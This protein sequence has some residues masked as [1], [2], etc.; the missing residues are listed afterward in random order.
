M[1]KKIDRNARLRLP[2]A[3]PAKVEQRKNAPR[4]TVHG[5]KGDGILFHNVVSRRKRALS[6]QC[7]LAGLKGFEVPC[8]RTDIVCHLKT[9]VSE[10]VVSQFVQRFSTFYMV[11]NWVLGSMRPKHSHDPLLHSSAGLHRYNRLQVMYDNYLLVGYK[12]PKK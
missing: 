2:R 8:A 4:K 9:C 3:G 11:A 5:T 10:N 6:P 1:H 12:S 7:F